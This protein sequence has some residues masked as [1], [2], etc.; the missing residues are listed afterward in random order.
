MLS[1]RR[2]DIISEDKR[3]S[4]WGFQFDL[5]FAAARGPKFR[6]LNETTQVLHYDLY[7]FVSWVSMPFVNA[8]IYL[9]QAV[10][11]ARNGCSCFKTGM[12]SQSCVFTGFDSTGR[13]PTGLRARLRNRGRLENRSH[14]LPKTRFQDGGDRARIFTH[15]IIILA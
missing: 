14:V 10:I 2:S 8:C 6:K 5:G 7:V 1:L 9:L 12:L 11:I 4:I 13:G 3:A 15:K